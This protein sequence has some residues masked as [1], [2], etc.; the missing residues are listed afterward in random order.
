MSEAESNTIDAELARKYFDRFDERDE[1]RLTLQ[2]EYLSACREISEEDKRDFKMGVAEGLPKAAFKLELK[3]HRLDRKHARQIENLLADEEEDTVEL[4][5]LIREKLGAFA[6]TPLG[7][8]TVKEAESAE[9]KVAKRRSKKS[10]ALDDL[11]SGKDAEAAA[12]NTA[13]L[14]GM[15]T[16]N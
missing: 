16:L 11:A 5:D 9:A 2:M 13:A 15:K 10:A 6:D 1:R 12:A 14:A 7:A 4:A 3:R 8:H